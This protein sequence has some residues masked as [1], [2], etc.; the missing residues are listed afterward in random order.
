MY[1]SRA[2]QTALHSTA[3]LFLKIRS[4]SCYLLLIRAHGLILLFSR[5]SRCLSVLDSH[6][7]PYLYPDYSIAPCP[8]SSIFASD[9]RL[10]HAKSTDMKL[11]TALALAA[12]IFA[13]SNAQ[14]CGVCRSSSSTIGADGLTD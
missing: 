14:S 3:P 13:T 10:N 5:V 4:T 1:A 8:I 12:S 9:Y 6:Y 2:R 7:R 11:A